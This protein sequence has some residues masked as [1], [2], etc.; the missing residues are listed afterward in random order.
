MR[1]TSLSSL[2]LK[3]GVRL[4]S[5]SSEKSLHRKVELNEQFGRTE[6]IRDNLNPDFVKKFVMEYFFEENTKLKFTI[7]DV[8]CKAKDVKKHDLLGSAE[9]TLAEL[10]RKGSKLEKPLKG[11]KKGKK[12]AIWVSAE[13]LSSCK[14]KVTLKFSGTNLDKKD[15]LGKS[16]P[17]LLFY[18][19]NSDGSKTV[20]HKTE[21][22]KNTLNPTWKPFTIPVL[23]LCNGDYHRQLTIKCFD[24]NKDG[25]TDEIG[26]FET[27]LNE[28]SA[29]PGPNQNFKCVNKKKMKKKG[30]TNS[31]TIVLLDYKLETPDTFL[32]YISGG[33]EVLCTFAVDFTKP[34]V[35][36]IKSSD[37]VYEQVLRAVGEIMELYDSDK[38]F[39]AL[40]FGA[41][42]PENDI[43]SHEF[44]LNGDKKDPYCQG[45]DGVI[46]AYCGALDRVAMSGPTN[47]APV[48]K[49]VAKIA[50]K[51]ED[52][53]KYFILIILTHSVIR[54]MPMTKQAI[55]KASTLPM[56]IVIVGLG[57]AD[58]TSM[59]ELDGDEK[60]L[61]H[62]GKCANR[63]IVQF[64]PFREFVKDGTKDGTFSQQSQAMLAKE[65]LAEIP[66][67]FLSYMKKNNFKPGKPKAAP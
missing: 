6:T 45:I 1:L 30:Y 21:V 3:P 31:G 32:D 17:F 28:L 62:Q 43:V 41:K 59:K 20:V 57:D 67:Q 58:F 52:G 44:F 36:E 40:G 33:T 48:I 19:M 50:Q 7:I 29:G 61:E 23:A 11:C 60:R 27:T 18:R 37:N 26:E 14:E 51:W 49:H 34:V 24:W 38:L 56:S 54:D 16:D 10:V 5:L 9:F 65:I 64:V 46:Q 47:F 63:D 66:E 39:P 25:S 8:D 53:T 42:M 15:V 22:I 12:A 13:E 55:I 4:T 35:G 2:S